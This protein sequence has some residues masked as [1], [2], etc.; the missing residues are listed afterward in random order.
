MITYALAMP[1]P[2][3]HRFEVTMRVDGVAGE[4]DLVMPS[5]AP[6]S[7]LLREFARHVSGFEAEDARGNALAWRKVAKGTWRVESGR[8]RTVVVRYRVYAN[9]LSVQTSHLDA[10]HGYVTGT[11]VFM[12]VDGRKEEPHEVRIAPP[13][14]WRV[15]TGLPSVRGRPNVFRAEGYDHLAD[16]PFEIGTHDLLRFTVEGKRHAIA[17]YGRGNLD[18][19]VLVADVKAIVRETAALFGGLPYK[20]YLFILHLAPKGAG[21]LEHA[22]STT[23][24]WDRFGFRP[25]KRYEEFLALVSHEFFHTW[26]V[27]RIRPESLGPFDYTKEN[28]TRLLWAMEGLTSYYDPLLCVRA[29]VW[30]EE[31]YRDYLAETIQKLRTQPGRFAES[32]EESSFDTWIKF[33]RQDE[34]YVNAGISYYLKGELLGVVLD[35]EIR[36]RTRGRRSLDDVFR[37]LWERHGRTG[38]PILEPDG[39]RAVA[40]EATGLDLRAFFADHVAGREELPLEEALATVGWTLE[41][42]FPEDDTKK[43]EKGEEAGPGASL[44][45]I[46]KG[47]AHA[48]VVKSVLAGAAGDRAGLAPDDEIVAL[49]GF[50]LRKEDDL[51]K[52]LKERLP[53]DVVALTLARRDEIVPLDVELGDNPPEKHAVTPAKRETAAHRRARRAWLAPLAK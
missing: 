49:D 30:S 27:K 14:G 21:G 20:D 5:W 26:N 44:G 46:L 2:A 39:W 34:N 9:D 36:R 4:V 47:D 33:Y 13:R 45:V 35:L 23:L 53:G 11:S 25:R 51:K 17:V 18:K 48:V 24:L 43:I 1:R 22:N 7:Y 32:L 41:A 16:C 3:D 42:K 37:L 19:K 50:R 40:E 12:H 6:G 38:V 29:G 8:A 28:H 52:R 10:T 31:R 15:S